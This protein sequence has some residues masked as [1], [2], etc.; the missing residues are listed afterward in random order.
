MS[1]T[2]LIE[3]IDQ[4]VKEEN[5]RLPVFDKVAM[6][7]QQ[8]VQGDDY[9]I[10]D[11]ERAIQ[12][13]PVLASEVLKAAN[14]PYFKG[15]VEIKS[16]KNAIVRLGSSQVVDLALMMSQRSSYKAEN[17]FIQKLMNRSWQGAVACAMTSR[18]ISDRLSFDDTSEVFMGG[19]LHD[20][21]YL[22]LLTVLDKL[23]STGRLQADFSHELVMELLNTLHADKGYELLA[24]WNLPEIYCVI[25]REHHLEEF[26]T[27]NTS[28]CIVRLADRACV[29]LG[30][31]IEH[32]PSIMLAETREAE[33]LGL[34]PIMLA[35]MEIMMEDSF[36]GVT[37]S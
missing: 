23:V 11:I 1:D 19:L 21:G 8:I 10:E 37:A 26:D 15:L 5:F 14:S 9:L 12:S 7:L 34:T 29:K 36:R 2:P 22:F 32:D 31:C 3:L 16:I 4:Y 35:E 20:I 28:L 6:K 25:A 27:S 17:P 30:L 24:D 13:D 33:E 18:W